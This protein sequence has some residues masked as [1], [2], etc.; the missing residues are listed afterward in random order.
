MRDLFIAF[1][2][3]FMCISTGLM[4]FFSPG[5]SAALNLLIFQNVVIMIMIIGLK[6]E[7]RNREYDV[8]ESYTM[9]TDQNGNFVRNNRRC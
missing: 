2:L 8:P 1:I 6:K 3:V 9:V 4:S 5:I 7:T